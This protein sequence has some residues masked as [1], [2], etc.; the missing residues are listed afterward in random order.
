MET[1]TLDEA[2]AQ[3]SLGKHRKSL[4]AYRNR[5]ASALPSGHWQQLSDLKQ[6]AVDSDDQLTAKAIWCLETI[7]QIQDQFVSAFQQVRQAE[8]KRAWD[9]LEQCENQIRSLDRHFEEQDDRFGVEFARIHVQRFQDIYPYTWGISPGMVHREM[10]CSVCKAPI[11][12]R[13]RCQHKNG[14]I[15]DGK[16]C[17]EIITGLEFLHFAIVDNPAQKFSMIA[18]DNDAPGYEGVKLLSQALRSPWDGW[19]YHKEQ[20][21]QFH[22]A[23]KSVGRNHPCPC[24]SGIKYK[25]CCMNREEVFPHFRFSFQKQPPSDVPRFVLPNGE[26]R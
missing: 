14:E 5:P 11:T 3:P 4:E 22:P 21:K 25:K 17:T 7:G 15:Y 24:D 13:S 19:W 26:T 6:L 2:I 23:Y 18:A 12:L 8:F 9:E 20:R 16:M 1:M 10:H